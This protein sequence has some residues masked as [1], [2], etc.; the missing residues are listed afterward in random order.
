MSRIAIISAP[1]I[2]TGARKAMRIIMLNAICT[3][4]TSVVKRVTSEAVENLSTFEN[5]NDCTFSNTA[6]PEF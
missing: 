6:L 5:E 1:T 2:M 4:F 3:L